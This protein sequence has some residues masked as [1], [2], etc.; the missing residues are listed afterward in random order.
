MELL[1]HVGMKK[2]H[3]RPT[4]RFIHP[5]Y[6]P[7][8]YNANQPESCNPIMRRRSRTSK[9]YNPK[10]TTN[11]CERRK[12][13]VHF[14]PYFNPYLKLAYLKDLILWYNAVS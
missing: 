1:I 6:T 2:G 12:F 8:I 7:E 5:H 11:T 3:H 13:E 14:L 9:A 4:V 10:P